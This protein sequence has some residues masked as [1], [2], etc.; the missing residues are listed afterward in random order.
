MRSIFWPCDSDQPVNAAYMTDILQAGYELI[1][2]RTGFGLKPMLRSGRTPIGTLDAIRAE[3][4]EVL[5][6][7][8]GEDGA[9][10]RE[11]VQALQR[12][13]LGEWKEDGGSR[14]D[15]VAFLESLDL[16]EIWSATGSDKNEGEELKVTDVHT[17]RDD[18]GVRTPT[19]GLARY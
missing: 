4:R 11:K 17:R 6:C 19:R 3:A 12:A 14:A 16:W 5:K 9:R 8:F 10:K 15:M 18:D 13:V 7:A 1:E 2:V